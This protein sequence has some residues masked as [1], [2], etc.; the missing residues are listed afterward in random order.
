M[1]HSYF[2]R[3]FYVRFSFSYDTPFMV[4]KMS[5]LTLVM[6]KFIELQITEFCDVVKIVDTLSI[7]IVHFS[8][9]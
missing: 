4:R 8:N 5:S 1:L 6:I 7:S 2:V 9:P 3:I